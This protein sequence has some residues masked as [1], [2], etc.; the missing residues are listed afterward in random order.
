VAAT[1][2]PPSLVQS[3]L[4]IVCLVVLL[5]GSVYLFGDASSA[6]PNQIALLLSAVVAA[7]VAARNSHPWTA[8]EAGIVRVI[9]SA[10]GAMLILL[11]VGAL[12]GTWILAGVVPAMIDYGLVLLTPRVFYAAACAICCLVAL[13]TGSSWTTAGTVGV[14]LVGVAAAQDLHLGMAAGAIISGAYFGDKMSPLSDTTNLAPAMAGTDLFTHIRAMVWTTGPALAIALVL[15]AVVGSTMAAPAET[16]AVAAIRDALG[17]SFALGWHLL[18]PVVLVL[19]LVIRRVPALPAL[20]AGTLAGAVFAVLFQPDVVVM[21]ADT[22]GLARPLALVKGVWMALFDGYVSASGNA[23]L[24]DLLTRGGIGSML[25]TIWLIVSAMTFGGVMETS[26]MLERLGA[27]VLGAARGTGGLVA[28]TLGTT[29]GANVVASDQYM[30]IVLPGRMFR[31]EFERR[32]L[33]P[34]LLSRTLED[35]GTITSPLVPWNTCGAFMAQTLG[36]ATVTYAPFAFFNLLNPL[37][38]LIYAATG[39]TLPRRQGP[40]R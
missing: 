31:P 12:I 32:G 8:I 25:T 38:A 20:V 37:V 34:E 11:T 13:A 21:L 22:P 28:A 14:A 5:A 18:L 29:I 3:A 26:G 6:G 9:A 30:A 7:L 15:F 16:D 35:G 24:D 19:V 17:Q 39:A 40:A 36:V 10:L 1:P 4:P 23:E 33:P 2:R 27:A